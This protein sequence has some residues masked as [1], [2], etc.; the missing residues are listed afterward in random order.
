MSRD[1]F[2]SIL[3]KLIPQPVLRG[4][5]E[6]NCVPFC[7]FVVIAYLAKSIFKGSVDLMGSGFK[8]VHN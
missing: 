4:A 2:F 3:A 6:A 5:L 1:A 8:Y 7:T